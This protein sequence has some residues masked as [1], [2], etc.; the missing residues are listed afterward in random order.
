MDFVFFQLKSVRIAEV[1]CKSP[2]SGRKQ[3]TLSRIKYPP[4]CFKI[5]L[6]PTKAGAGTLTLVW[7]VTWPKYFLQNKGGR[8]WIKKIIDLTIVRP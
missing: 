1:Q 3:S 6:K 2:V 7:C 5:I 8:E 4:G